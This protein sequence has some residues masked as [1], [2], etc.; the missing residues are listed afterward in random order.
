MKYSLDKREKYAIFKI[1][2]EKVDS[3][4]SPELKSQF[5]FLK[6]EGVHNLIV[7]M[8]EVDYIDSSGLSAILTANRL[9]KEEGFFALTRIDSDNVRK[10]IE[11]S[12]LHTILK[13]TKDLEEAENLLLMDQVQKHSEQDD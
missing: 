7:D 4:I 5:I 11:I 2:E 6:N 10:I 8:Q 9:W 3:L 13:I 12:R 1:Q